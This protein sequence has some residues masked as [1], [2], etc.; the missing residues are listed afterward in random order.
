MRNYLTPFSRFNM[1]DD[2]FNNRESFLDR[3][4]T[5]HGG[6]YNIIRKNS[7]VYQI[8]LNVAGF[9]KEDV[10]ITFEGNIITIKGST[11]HEDTK[12]YIYQGFSSSFQNSFSIEEGSEVLGAEIKD[13]MLAIDIKEKKTIANQSQRIAIK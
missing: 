5:K 3:G 11:R 10:E 2:F 9:R 12:D 6:N 8:V 13:G 4:L 7:E 1:L